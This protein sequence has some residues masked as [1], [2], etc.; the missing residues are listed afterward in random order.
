MIVF[1][2]TW[3]CGALV[4]PLVLVCLWYRIYVPAYV[5]M[6]YYGFRFLFPA[7][8]SDPIREFMGITSTP[9]YRTQ[10]MVFDEGA[11]IP[12]PNSKTMLAVGPHGVLC[13][14]W[15]FM[16]T[17][18]EFTKSDITWLIAE[19]L[20][21]LPFCK[22]FMIWGNGAPCTAPHFKRLMPTGTNIALLP[23]GFEEATLYKRG[24]YRLFLN[25]RKG[26][27]KYALQY[28]YKV[29]PAYVFGEEQTFWTLEVM[30]SLMLWL[31]KFN[32]PGVV[33]IGKW[34]YLPDPNVDIIPC[35]GKAIE[36]PHIENPT[37]EDVDKYHAVYVDNM[38]KLFDKFKGKH[39]VDGDKAQLE[40]I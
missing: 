7:R 16:N 6:V 23:G 11:T 29:Q 14:G 25:N 28:G 38:Q 32:I 36:L 30:P 10:K 12:E 8:K 3:T 20:F 18:K 33:F 34:G 39:A 22:D 37:S 40:I 19:I 5:L 21:Y 13:C 2:T 17:C 1:L 26:F 15:C 24:Q 27:I 4:F 35:V 9:Y 31:N